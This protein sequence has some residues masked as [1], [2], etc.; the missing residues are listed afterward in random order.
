MERIRVRQ[1]KAINVQL[2]SSWHGMFCNVYHKRWL[3]PSIARPLAVCMQSVSTAAFFLSIELFWSHSRCTRKRTIERLFRR[4]HRGVLHQLSA[5][6]IAV[7]ASP[8]LNHSGER[9][10]R[11]LDLRLTKGPGQG[12]RNGKKRTSSPLKVK[13]C[14]SWMNKVLQTHCI[15]FP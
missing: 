11:C 8:V 3:D 14:T 15:A 6:G 4:H 12:L 5:I 10:V 9:A 13:Y 2:V 1:Q 7:S